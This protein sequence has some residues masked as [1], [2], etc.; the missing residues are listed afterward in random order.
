MEGTTGLSDPS[1]FGSLLDGLAERPSGGE[2][3]ARSA[4][5]PGQVE[6]AEGKAPETAGASVANSI[7]ALLQGILPNGQSQAS[8][9]T[10]DANE[11]EGA[12]T[13]QL[14]SSE[15]RPSQDGSELSNSSATSRLMV[16]VKHQETHFKPIIE[17]VEAQLPAEHTDGIRV[18]SDDAPVGEFA[19]RTSAGIVQQGSASDTRTANLLSLANETP[20]E[21]A[22]LREDMSLEHADKHSIKQ[23][24]E[25]S[26][27]HR[28]S[29]AGTKARADSVNLPSETLHGMASAI[30]TSLESAAE[31]AAERPVQESGTNRTISIKASES[32][33]R[34]LNLQLQPAELGMVTIKM[35]LAGES[36][37]MELHVEREET[38]QLLRQ[39]SEKLSA[40]LR[41]SG[42]RPDTISIQV[43][44]GIVHERIVTRTQ[45]DTQMQAQSFLQGG[46][47]QGGRSRDQEKPNVHTKAEH[48]K[49]SDGDRILDGRSPGGVYL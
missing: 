32:A 45:A 4:N 35:R 22:S 5:D 6:A 29:S 40:L 46:G 38:A 28:A 17:Q 26:D 2:T 24:S 13:S 1:T 12:M 41:G 33:L 15:A 48:H 19:R 39:D 36:L 47:G 10:P 27:L 30:R 20:P 37:E 43:G 49:N 31:N 23:S 42:Y 14:L 7:F 8:A 44:D 3:S 34:V 18:T 25:H 11:Q 9:I 21:S 16:E